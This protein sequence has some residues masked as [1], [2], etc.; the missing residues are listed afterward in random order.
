MRFFLAVC[1]NILVSCASFAD[2]PDPLWVKAI[3][4]IKSSKGWAAKQVE[5]VMDV[6]KDD[7]KKHKVI[8]QQLTGWEKDQPVYTVV[9]VVPAL[10]DPANP[11]KVPDILSLFTKVLD[12]IYVDDAAVKRSDGVKLN[13]KTLS[14]FEINEG[15]LQ[16]VVMKIWVNSETGLVHQQQLNV[17][18]PLT[19]EANVQMTYDVENQ[20]KNFLTSSETQMEI[21]TPFKK[22]K[23]SIK[24]TYTQWTVA[25]SK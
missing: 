17:Y 18:M 8:T 10:R 9:S 16:K 15:S 6:Q 5:L 24:T 2:T 3:A 25:G 22:A 13:G 4:N 12:K 14:L 20:G 1:A 7:E 21:L 11:P 19:V 23:G